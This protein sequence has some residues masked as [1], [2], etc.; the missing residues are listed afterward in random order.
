[1]A[2]TEDI[3]NAFGGMEK[4]SEGLIDHDIST[5]GTMLDIL[6]KAGC[7]Y[8]DLMGEEHPKLPK[9]RLTALLSVNETAEIVGQIMTIM[10][11]DAERTVE[12]RS[13]N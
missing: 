4:M 11:E 10:T 9:G 2:A 8:C 3:I 1:M 5:V 13:K 12:V 7:E 6:I